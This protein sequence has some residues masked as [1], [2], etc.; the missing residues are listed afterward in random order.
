MDAANGNAKTPFANFLRE[1]GDEIAE[2]CS[3]VPALPTTR[4]KWRKFF[5]AVTPGE[6]ESLRGLIYR[7]CSLNSLPNV[8]GLLK[9][10]G[11]AH[12]N[13]VIVAEDPNIAVDELAYAVG[14]ADEE[15]TLRRYPALGENRR[16]FFGLEIQSTSFETRIRRFSPEAFR[17]DAARP[18]E[19]RNE[20]GSVQNIGP[21]HR[22]T[23]ELRDIP[24]DLQNWDLLHDTCWCEPGGVVQGWSRTATHINECDKCGD[25]LANLESFYVPDDMRPALSILRALVD[26]S[27]EVRCSAAISLPEPIRN[28]DRSR[29][30]AIVIRMARAIDPV[31]AERVIEQPRLRLRGLWQ[32]CDALAHWPDGIKTVKWTPNLHQTTIVAITK[33]WGK[34]A[35]ADPVRWTSRRAKVV[36]DDNIIGMSPAAQKSKLSPEILRWAHET[37][38]LTQHHH[39]HGPRLV[40]AFDARELMH[41][42]DEWRSRVSLK[43]LAFELGIS[44]HGAEQLVA[45]GLISAEAP[46]MP[47][48]G[49]YCYPEAMDDFINAIEAVAAGGGKHRTGAIKKPVSLLDAMQWVTGRSKPYGPAIA[50]MLDGKIPFAIQAGPRFVDSIVVP[51]AHISTIAALRF[52]RAKFD[53]FE[54]SE[55]I[56]QRDAL[57]MLNINTAGSGRRVLNTLQSS[58]AKPKTYLVADVEMLAQDFVTLPD[59]A[60]RIGMSAA[61]AYSHLCKLGKADMKPG[62]WSRQILDELT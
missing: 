14:V 44:H 11:L 62:L 29:I 36:Q 16:S 7:A 59:I 19:T 34:L 9:W 20:T 39:V 21:Y 37:N 4:D 53:D 50:Q 32:A 3:R 41:F 48:A 31:A 51:S 38:R 35:C 5:K 33:D 55:R 2:T 42:S 17:A 22:A 57:H 15:I 24:F 47:G 49:L 58:G 60:M 61:D 13:R 40:P 56:I 45:L 18:V 26:P 12:R 23:W 54:F 30:F 52:D 46:A 27:E 43:S 8:W 1:V 10:V 6:G 28:A 25:P